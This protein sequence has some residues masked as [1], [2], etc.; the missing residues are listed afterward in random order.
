[1]RTRSD[2]NFKRDNACVSVMSVCVLQ[3]GTVKEYISQ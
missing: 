3:P 2:K 1:M